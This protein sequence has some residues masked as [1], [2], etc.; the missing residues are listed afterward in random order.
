MYQ[1]LIDTTAPSG[2]WNLIVTNDETGARIHDERIGE[3]KGP[4][5]MTC[6]F[7]AVNS[8]RV[9]LALQPS[10]PGGQPLSISSVSLRE[11]VVT[12]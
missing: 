11:L 3:P 4:E 10:G 8:N 12:E 9:T 1:V 7:R 5:R 6:V 2:R